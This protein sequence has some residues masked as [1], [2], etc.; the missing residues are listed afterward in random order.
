[1]DVCVVTFRN[2][3]HRIAASLRPCD[4]LYVRDNTTDNI[5]FAAGANIAAAQGSDA[6]I[7]FV[8]PDGELAP[9]ALDA[10]ERAFADR[11][12]VAAEASQ[13]LE[14]DRGANP[15]WLSGACLAVR[16]DAFEAVGGFDARLFMYGE[17]VDISY[18][19]APLGS[20]VHVAEARFLHD[21]SPG[22]CSL[23]A[24]HRNFRN[25]L[26]V[27]RRHRRADP[28]R[29]LRDAAYALRCRQWIAALARVTGTLDYL[30]RAHRWA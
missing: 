17:D 8:N 12:V 28:M 22:R 21:R 29:M 30:A 15:E 5:G 27:A 13:G 3:A 14:W 6:L 9:G 10:L 7:L 16:R 25:W 19:L 23:V 11:D 1:M 24:Q 2:D 18:R 26:V 20:L 4:R